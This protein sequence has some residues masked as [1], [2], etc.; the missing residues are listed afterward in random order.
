[1]RIRRRGCHAPRSNLRVASNHE[2][3]LLLNHPLEPVLGPFEER[4]PGADDDGGESGAAYATST[5]ISESRSGM[6]TITS[7]PQGAS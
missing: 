1:M 6:S 2:R 3:L 4:T 7:C 5:R